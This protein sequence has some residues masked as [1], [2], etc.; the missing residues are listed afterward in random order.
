MS[1]IISY[2][3]LAAKN[4]Q[5]SMATNVKIITYETSTKKISFIAGFDRITNK[6]VVWVE[7]KK[8]EKIEINRWKKRRRKGS[9]DN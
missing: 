5:I 3:L 4:I 1:S 9:G 6:T 2:L 8:K 7:K